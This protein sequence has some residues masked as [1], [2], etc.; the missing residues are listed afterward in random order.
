MC[1]ASHLNARQWCLA[2]NLGFP[3]EK[4]TATGILL[5]DLPF[6][7]SSQERLIETVTVEP[8]ESPDFGLKDYKCMDSCS[9][10]R[11]SIFPIIANIPSIF[12]DNAGRNWFCGISL[13]EHDE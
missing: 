12:A 7:M 5:F 13:I 10:C 3:L 2:Y 9:R 8:S 11:V 6:F 1:D 4:R